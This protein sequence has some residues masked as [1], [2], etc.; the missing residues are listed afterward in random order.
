MKTFKAV[1]TLFI[2][3]TL[4]CTPSTNPGKV[5]GAAETKDEGKPKAEQTVDEKALR[6][7]GE[8]LLALEQ[9]RYKAAIPFDETFKEVQFNAINDFKEALESKINGEITYDTASTTVGHIINE[10]ILKCSSGTSLLIIG[11]LKKVPADKWNDLNL[12]VI[13]TVIGGYA[14]VLPGYLVQD[15]ENFQLYGIETTALRSGLVEFGQTDKLTVPVEVV[16][17]LSWAQINVSKSK[18][19]ARQ[20]VQDTHKKYKIPFNRILA[21]GKGSND[22]GLFGFGEEMPALK[23]RRAA[24]PTV[25][26]YTFEK[27][28]SIPVGEVNAPKPEQGKSE[29]PATKPAKIPLTTARL[30]SGMT[31]PKEICKSVTDIL[32]RQNWESI[33]LDI[34]SVYDVKTGELLTGEDLR[35]REQNTTAAIRLERPIISR[36]NAGAHDVLVLTRGYAVSFGPALPAFRTMAVLGESNGACVIGADL[37]SATPTPPRENS[38]FGSGRAMIMVDPQGL[39]RNEKTLAFAIEWTNTLFIQKG[40]LKLTRLADEGPRQAATSP[41]YE[42]PTA[43]QPFPET[44]TTIEQENAKDSS[45]PAL[46]KK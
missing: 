34:S 27:S 16:D 24:A 8:K 1:S 10:K 23:T 4:A 18:T 29:T 21:D 7:A 31:A 2:F 36:K 6:E 5:M 44:D 43:A 46:N 39:Q 35:K 3:A 37:E 38:L 42:S 26:A 22:D 17:A 12:V 30:G 40:L 28:L 11:A 20:A 9:E 33:D 41:R 15:G 32:A 14:H 25:A 13:Y 45:A 19:A